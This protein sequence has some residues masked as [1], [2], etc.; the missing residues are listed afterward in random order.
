MIRT[1]LLLLMLM[2]STGCS[3]FAL[4][5]SVGGGF[6]TQNAYVRAYNGADFLTVIQ[7]DKSIK[8]HIYKKGK[9]YIYDQTVGFIKK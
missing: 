9:V 6:A 5:A 2:V 4:I 7:T 3:E 8:K 1:T